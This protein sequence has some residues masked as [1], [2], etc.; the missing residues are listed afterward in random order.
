MATCFV[1][2]K[3]DLKPYSDSTDEESWSYMAYREARRRYWKAHPF[4]ENDVIVY[5]DVFKFPKTTDDWEDQVRHW[6]ETIE[7]LEKGLL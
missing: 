2:D 5:W 7:R 1:N 6:C 3:G 4:G